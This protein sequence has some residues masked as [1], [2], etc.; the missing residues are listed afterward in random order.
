MSFTDFLLKNKKEIAD[1]EAQDYL[2]RVIIHPELSQKIYK[3]FMREAINGDF[4]PK[5]KYTKV[6]FQG[7]SIEE[8]PVSFEDITKVLM[9]TKKGMAY[10]KKFRLKE[11]NSPEVILDEYREEW[12]KVEEL[13]EEEGKSFMKELKEI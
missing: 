8:Y 9:I 11:E 13:I 5:R 3:A 6:E 7:I 4:L 1:W 2:E 12:K 10:F